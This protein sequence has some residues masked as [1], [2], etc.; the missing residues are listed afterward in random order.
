[1][2]LG[3]TA[4]LTLERD[5]F[6]RFVTMYPQGAAAVFR[7]LAALIRKQNSQLYGQFFGG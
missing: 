5:E 2:T 7:S 6:L 1:M 3:R 4:I